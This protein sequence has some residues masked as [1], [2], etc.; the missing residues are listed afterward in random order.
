MDAPPGLSEPQQRRR[1]SPHEV[2]CH[3]SAYRPVQA[4][5]RTVQDLGV[6]YLD[7]P[8]SPRLNLTRGQVA[9]LPCTEQRNDVF[10]AEDAVFFTVE[11][12]CLPRP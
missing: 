4:A 2:L 12:P 10:V 8:S 7:R 1:R 5:V 11:P 9:Q 6:E 3:R